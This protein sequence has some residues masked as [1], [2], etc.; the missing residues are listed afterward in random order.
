[1]AIAWQDVFCHCIPRPPKRLELILPKV[2]YMS[3][4]DH[5]ADCIL[6]RRTDRTFPFPFYL[7]EGVFPSDI[8]A[9]VQALDCNPKSMVGTRA[10]H[11]ATRLYFTEAFQAE[12]P[13]AR[14][15]CEAF[16]SAKVARAIASNSGARLDDTHLLV[17]LSADTGVSELVP[18]RDIGT[19]RF[20]GLFYISDDPALGHCGTDFYTRRPDRLN[21]IADHADRTGEAPRALFEEKTVR[22]PYG[23]GL[24]YYF[25]PSDVSWH[26]F[27]RREINGVRK[28]IIVNYIGV[29]ANGE[30]YRN[31][32][33]L[34][35]PDRPV[36]L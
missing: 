31:V 3:L 12:N 28:T 5:I 19:K 30:R 13:V 2:V 33:N 6:N 29:A 10:Q 14:S 34:A 27:D 36:R 26:G 21:E 32:Q 7:L 20:T 22:P 18:H 25:I 4:D 9:K 16:Q 11:N 17:E 15:I 23:P 1:M 35:F 8:I 24:G